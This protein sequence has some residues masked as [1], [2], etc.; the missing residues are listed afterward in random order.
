MVSFAFP[1]F[2]LTCRDNIDFLDGKQ[3][4]FG[5]IA[6]AEGLETLSKI[7]EAFV[8]ERNRPLYDIR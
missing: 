3:T 6:E 5:E 4:V 7:N 8:D 1:Q 2:V